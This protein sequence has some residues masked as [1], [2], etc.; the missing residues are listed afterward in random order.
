MET[1]ATG[2]TRGTGGTGGTGGTRAR[3]LAERFAAANEDLARRLEACDDAHWHARTGGEGWPVSLVAEHVAGANRVVWAWIETLLRTGAWPH[4]TRE[5]IDSSNEE[6]AA[7]HTDLGRAVLVS[8]L[9]DSAA[10]VAGRIAAL[11][12][13]DLDRA[14]PFAAADGR[15]VSVGQG[16][17]TILLR[18]VQNHGK[19]IAETLGA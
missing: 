11:S 3:E 4:V 17:V 1:G 2:M 14:A 19:S 6:R 12:D 16:I 7:A 5:M 13:A 15:A 8:R 10:E 18:H 9:R